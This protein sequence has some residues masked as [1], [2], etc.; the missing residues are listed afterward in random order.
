MARIV[1]R[2]RQARLDYQSREG[3][4]VTVEDVADA[5][6]ISRQSLSDI[7]NGRKLPRYRTLA[8]ICKFY[9]LQPGDL[10]VYEDRLA[11]LLA[12][13]QHNTNSRAEGEYARVASTI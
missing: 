7:E 9:S 11:R 8:A 4:V 10:L 6:K 2:F 13:A 1:G 5:I 12:V 3:R